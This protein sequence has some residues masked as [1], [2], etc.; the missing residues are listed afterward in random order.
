M[1]L[2]IYVISELCVKMLFFFFPVPIFIEKLFI[3][4]ID[5]EVICSLV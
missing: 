5:I 2:G 4:Q 3:L 1:S